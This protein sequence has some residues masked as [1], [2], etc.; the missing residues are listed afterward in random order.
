MIGV[1]GRTAVFT[2]P[3][4]TQPG[5]SGAWTLVGYLEDFTVETVAEPGEAPVVTEPLVTEVVVPSD[6]FR[7]LMPLSE[8]CRRTAQ[9]I[10]EPR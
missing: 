8:Q 9:A 5:E 1:D 2:A 4:G 10:E 3:A 7:Q 6:L